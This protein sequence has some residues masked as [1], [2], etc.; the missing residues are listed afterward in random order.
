[1]TTTAATPITTRAGVIDDSADGPPGGEPSHPDID[2]KM[3]VGRFFFF[4]FFFVFFVTQHSLQNSADGWLLS[5]FKRIANADQHFPSS[6]KEQTQ[7]AKSSGA[8]ECTQW[9]AYRVKT[10][11]T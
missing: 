1:M 8:S 9:P 3:D 5:A 6:A 2:G 11:A 10:S 4:F 7:R